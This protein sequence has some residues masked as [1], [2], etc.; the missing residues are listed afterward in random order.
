M[1]TCL[2]LVKREQIEFRQPLIVAVIPPRTSAF[3]KLGAK[4]ACRADY[5]QVRLS[6]GKF[7]ATLQG[8]QTPHSS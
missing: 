4:K 3:L 2:I 6:Q 8:R 1:Q 7:A 5:Q